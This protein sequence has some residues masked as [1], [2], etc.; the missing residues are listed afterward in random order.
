MNRE[1]PV[2][3]MDSGVGGLTVVKEMVKILP[4]ED[5]IYFGDSKRMPYGNR[6][7]EEIVYLANE[8]IAFLENKGVKAIL[9]ACNTVSSQMDK[10]THRVP[11]FG[12]IEAGC[13]A[14]LENS[15][16]EEIGLIATVA[17]VKSGVYEKTLERL[18]GNR[19]FVSND[20]RKLPQIINDQLRHRY[21]LD[22]HIHECIDPILE[23]GS[24]RELVLGCS[25]FPIIEKEIEEI[26]PHLRL[27]NPANKQ[28]RMLEAYLLESSLNKTDKQGDLT[29]Y[30]TARVQEFRETMD[31]LGM[32]NYTLEKVALLEEDQQDLI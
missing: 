20:S 4:E 27:I 19:K 31:R 23:Q 14:V 21:L 32:E 5:V 25:H 15:D 18:D 11:L 26:Y 2:G 24:I 3:V 29:V 7:E 1:R 22:K 16:S 30:T 13:M 9:L 17:T 12:I 6:S 28:V 8:I 10:L